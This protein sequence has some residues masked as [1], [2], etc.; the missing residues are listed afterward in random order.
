MR[1]LG[2]TPTVW[3]CVGAR[4]WINQPHISIP[5]FNYGVRLLYMDLNELLHALKAQGYDVIC[6][7]TKH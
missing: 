7:H 5:F 6:R 2:K 4:S 1:I 3:E